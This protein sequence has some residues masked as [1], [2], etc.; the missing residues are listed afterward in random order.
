[1]QKEIEIVEILKEQRPNAV[2]ELNWKTPLDF[3]AAVI[4]S[5]QTTDKG[6]N[7]ITPRL[8]EKYKTPEDY[9]NASLTELEDYVSSINFFRTKAK[10]IKSACEVII[11]R[12]CGLVP[13]TMDDLLTIP[14]IGRKSA[15]V[16]LINVFGK[17]EGV[18]VDTHIARVSQRLGLTKEKDATK[19]EEDLIKVYP[20]KYW[21]D[22]SNLLV[23]HGRY[24]CKA[25][26]P[27]CLECLISHLCPAKKVFVARYE[28]SSMQKP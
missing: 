12:F 28:M 18:V 14:G 20:K 27:A 15:N 2:L 25:R 10:R 8:F 3:M 26:K 4:L 17:T 5:A 9:A 23:L 22:V 13:Q 1:M 6:V 19:I 16:I 11:S 7:K 24:V 21:A